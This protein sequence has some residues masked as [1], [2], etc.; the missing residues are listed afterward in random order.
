MRSASRLTS[1]AVGN[2]FLLIVTRGSGLSIF[3]YFDAGDS[4]EA[5]EFGRP[6]RSDVVA[7]RGVSD[8]MRHIAA[9]DAG[10]VLGAAPCLDG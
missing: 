7:Y 1:D 2:R 9:K 8:D 5:I 6:R 4:V 10:V 3:V